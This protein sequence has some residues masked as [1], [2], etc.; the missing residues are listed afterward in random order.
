[1]IIDMSDAAGLLRI[2]FL[3]IHEAEYDR[4]GS[5]MMAATATGAELDSKRLSD[6]SVAIV[7]YFAAFGLAGRIAS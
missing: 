7:P 1:M 6:G 5:A 4:T 3:M 2:S